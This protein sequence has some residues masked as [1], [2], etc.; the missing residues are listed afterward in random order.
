MR[1]YFCLHLRCV[2]FVLN[3]IFSQWQKNEGTFFLSA[4]LP[5]EVE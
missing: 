1:Y 5:V 4:E 2:E 3:L